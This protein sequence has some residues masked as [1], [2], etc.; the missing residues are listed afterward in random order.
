MLSKLYTEFPKVVVPS[1]KIYRPTIYK[2]ISS[3]QLLLEIDYM[4]KIIVRSIN[5]DQKIYFYMHI[6]VYRCCSAYLFANAKQYHWRTKENI[7][8]DKWMGKN[9]G[10][11]QCSSAEPK[12]C[13]N[14]K[15][16]GKISYLPMYYYLRE[17]VRF[18]K[19][20]PIFIVIKT[21]NA[22]KNDPKTFLYS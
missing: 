3:R 11:S 1:I 12:Y 2:Q 6:I 8:Y 10:Y 5:S 16:Q 4:Y 13:T 20:A 22:F 15:K 19:L 7:L 9:S 17:K 14:C 18:T 21:K